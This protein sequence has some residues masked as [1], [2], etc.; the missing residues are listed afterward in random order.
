MRRR[1][2]EWTVVESYWFG[3]EWF[4]VSVLVTMELHQPFTRTVRPAGGREGGY[5]QWTAVCSV[6]CSLLCSL[7]QHSKSVQIA[8]NDRAGLLNQFVKS[9][10]IAD[11]KS[12]SPAEHSKETCS[13]HDRLIKALHHCADSLPPLI[14]FAL[15]SFL[16]WIFFIFTWH[17][18]VSVNQMSALE[19]L[20]LICI[21]Q[22]N[23][24]HPPPL[25]SPHSVHKWLLFTLQHIS[26]RVTH[27]KIYR[28]FQ[29]HIF[30]RRR[31]LTEGIVNFIKIHADLFTDSSLF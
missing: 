4:P 31:V 5:P 26:M 24:S 18:C 15:G 17:L 28:P 19:F 10:N 11:S 13:F 2:Q 22:A 27:V 7:C 23:V 30:E 25:P 3:Q 16:K 1:H 21:M 8:A 14:F 6:L 20:G 9:V 29:C 12:A